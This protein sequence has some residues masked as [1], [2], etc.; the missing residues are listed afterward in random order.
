MAV[1]QFDLVAVP[2]CA[3]R[4][5]FQDLPAQI[6]TE[7]FAT[8]DWWRDQ[9]PPDD[10]ELASLL[11][12]STSW[13]AAIKAWGASDGNRIELYFDNEA[14]AELTIRIDLRD[15]NKAFMNGIL[16][17][18]TRHDYM[19]WTED[20]SLLKPTLDA[21]IPEIAKSDAFSFVRDPHA[22]LD[23]L[24]KRPSN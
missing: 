9:L 6:P 2:R 22:F 7:V 24:S 12:P 16:Q 5:A 10:S 13:T 20:E 4:D 17:L 3:V 14:F 1:W 18:A 15:L 8:R 21:L 19:F 23:Q 11:A